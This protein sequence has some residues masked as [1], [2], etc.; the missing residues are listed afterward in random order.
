MVLLETKILHLV[1]EMVIR[2]QRQPTKWE[3][4]I[5]SYTSDKGLITRIYRKLKKLYSQKVK[6]KE[7]SKCPEQSFSKGRSPN[8]Q[9]NT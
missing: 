8:G 3:K 2:L 9:K 4:I 1:E 6:N 5:A 7:M